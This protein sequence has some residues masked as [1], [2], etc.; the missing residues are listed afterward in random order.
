M[1]KPR[2]ADLAKLSGPLNAFQRVILVSSLAILG[3][4]ITVLAW[5]ILNAVLWQPYWREL[6][7]IGFYTHDV[8]AALLIT[9]GP[10][11]IALL[12][13]VGGLAEV[14]AWSLSGRKSRFRP[15]AFFAGAPS[16][17]MIGN[18]F[19]NEAWDYPLAGVTVL[20]IAIL[21]GVAYDRI[22]LRDCA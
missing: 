21:L 5:S 1:T 6:R 16:L 10:P 2:M 9:I 17:L 4:I 11:A 12:F 19:R 7:V 3:G 15:I 18:S 14:I 20:L 13:L 22:A 8:G